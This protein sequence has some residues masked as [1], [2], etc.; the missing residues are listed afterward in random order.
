[1]K[2][3]NN[4]SLFQREQVRESL[5]QSL[6]KL[7]PGMM[8]RN[9]IMFTVEIATMIML[10]VTVYSLFSDGQGDFLYN[11]LVFVILF[12]TLLFANF[13]EAIAEARGKA[14]ADS[15]RRTREET[16]AKLIV[17]GT[18]TVINSSQLKKGDYFE[19][20]AGDIIPADG[21]VVEGLASIDESAIT[22]ES[23]PVIRESGGD[24]S[25]VTG[26]TKVLSDRIKVLVTARPGESFLDKMIA[27]VEGASRQKTPNEIALTILLAVF[28]LVFLVVCITLK[29]A[30]DY[31]GTEIS[32]AALISL[33]VCLIPTTIGGLLSAI[34]IAG[35][36]RALRANV[37]TKS[38]KAVETA[39]DISTLLLDKTGTITIGNRKATG[40]FPVQGFDKQAFV[41]ACLMSS[42][43]D[44]TPEGKSI[45]ELGHEYGVHMRNLH[46][47][48]ARMIQFTAETKCSGINL[49]DG[50]EIRKGAFD[51]IRKI[52]EEAGNPFPKEAEEIIERVAGNGGT[53]L[54]VCINRKVVG[55][56]ELQDIIKPGIEERFERLRKMGVKTVMV[57]GDNPST[58]RYIAEKAGVDDFIAEAKP[59][60]KLSY[61]RKEQ[62]SG[63]LVAMMGDGTND[64][65]A[66]AQAD[67]GVAMNS[68]TQAAKEAGNMVDLDND[69]H[70][71]D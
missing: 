9:P 60:D 32:I 34:G 20:V 43:S 70:Q 56:I 66:L 65:P 61:I 45:I 63:K 12:L 7:H 36:N 57:T 16:P 2:N 69:P 11:F 59:E 68:G 26:G 23:A 64:A 15:L 67:V 40:F 19:C 25:S 4:T 71:I 47:E 41:E 46:T 18:V 21:E 39:G 24:K 17:D 31:S 51:T 30:A 42:V 29:P 50:T 35:M 62:A 8:M 22:G 38:G 55:V 44:D 49:S 1:M 33:F 5:K 13:A 48:G 54:V 27:L 3:S 28:T 10:L 37:I 53:P 58:A 52:A 14:Q 6:I